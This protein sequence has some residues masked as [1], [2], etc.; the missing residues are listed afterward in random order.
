MR[1]VSLAPLV[2]LVLAGCGSVAGQ[3]AAVTSHS[4][5]ALQVRAGWTRFNDSNLSLTFDYPSK[6]GTLTV[7]PEDKLCFTSGEGRRF[8]FSSLATVGA[9][10]RSK[11]YVWSSA[12]ARGGSYLDSPAGYDGVAN[13]RGQAWDPTTQS[14]RWTVLRADDRF[15]DALCNSVAKFVGLEAFVKLGG[16]K[17]DVVHFYQQLRSPR[18]T[19]AGVDVTGCERGADLFAPISADFTDVVKSARNS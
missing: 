7:A 6:W 10:M 19:G 9:T 15:I 2:A 16:Q 17:F 14:G 4:A 8:G 3:P 13:L 11:D 5:S 12:C 18:A 1:Y